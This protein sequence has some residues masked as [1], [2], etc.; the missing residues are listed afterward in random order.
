MGNQGR[1]ISVDYD[2]RRLGSWRK[3]TDHMG[4]TNATPV[5]GDA[6][7]QGGLPDI[8]ADVVLLDP[9]CTGTGTF[10]SSPSSKWRI[11]QNSVHRM[12]ELQ[13]TL[14]ANAS[15]RLREGGAL[16]YSTCSVTL[17]ENEGV[18]KRFLEENPSFKNVETAPRIG[19]QGLGGL[20]GAQRLYP[21]IHRCQ[22]FFI[23]K[24]TKN[25]ELP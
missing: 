9:P 25:N 22:G 7:K 4:V 5:L 19:A 1:I 3:L 17:E 15:R 13:S 23:A 6:T 14:I 11:N 10:H 24:L 8:E 20:T 2:E 21:H 18:I 12:A 16:I